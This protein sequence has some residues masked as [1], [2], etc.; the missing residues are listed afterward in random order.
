M[1]VIDPEGKLFSGRVGNMI[2]YVMNGRTYAR[3]VAV[4]EKEPKERTEGQ[5]MVTGRFKAVQRLFSLFHNRLSA[6]IW[7][8]AAR[9]EGRRASGL[10]HS[11]NC[12]CVD[13]TGCVVQPSLFRF[14]VGSLVLPTG[15]RVESDGGGAY[16]VEWDAGEEWPTSAATDRLMVGVL[17]GRDMDSPRW[18]A[19]VSGC[20][21]DGCGSFRLEE[22]FG[23]DAHAYV[24]FGRE[25]GSAY[26]P[27]LYFKL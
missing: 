16:R 4:S 13:A 22:R 11:V 27:S 15:V 24:F 12:G 9:E 10:F 26:S 18:A 25:D 23:G 20:R 2:Y 17:Y 14:S 6:D 1:K 3:R 5:R 21:G 8:V 19:E 7:R